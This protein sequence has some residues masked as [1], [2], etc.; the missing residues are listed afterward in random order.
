MAAKPHIEW[1]RPMERRSTFLLI[2]IPAS[3]PHSPAMAALQ[4]LSK[5]RETGLLLIGSASV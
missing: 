3:L 4:F 2:E 5:Y 1:H